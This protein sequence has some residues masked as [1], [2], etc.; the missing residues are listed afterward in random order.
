MDAYR[1]KGVKS[2]LQI[3]ESTPEKV[4]QASKPTTPADFASY[5]AMFQISSWPGGFTYGVLPETR[6]VHATVD[7]AHMLSG[8]IR[9]TAAGEECNYNRDLSSSRTGRALGQSGRV[10]LYFASRSRQ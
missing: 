9:F 10:L 2:R 7:K 5:R 6:V 4:A 1:V 8:A 3:S